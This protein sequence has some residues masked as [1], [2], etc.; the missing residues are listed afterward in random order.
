MTTVDAVPSV[1]PDDTL[2]V[3]LERFG[4]SD[5]P[6]LAVLQRAMLVGL[7]HREALAGYLKMRESLGQP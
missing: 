3:T 1:S 2:V 5:L 7:L 6:V 4:S